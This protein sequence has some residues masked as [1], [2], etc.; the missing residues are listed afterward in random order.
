VGHPGFLVPFHLLRPRSRVVVD[1]SK[2]S[3]EGDPLARRGRTGLLA[4]LQF[5]S[6]RR[7]PKSRLLV[8]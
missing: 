1:T 3:V 7:P 5:A 4:G 2:C 6:D 8:G